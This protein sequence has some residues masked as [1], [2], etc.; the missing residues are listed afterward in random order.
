MLRKIRRRI[1]RLFRRR[2]ISVLSA[3]VIIVLILKRFKPSDL[4]F[5]VFTRGLDAKSLEATKNLAPSLLAANVGVGR[6]WEGPT[7]NG[8]HDRY[9]NHKK[10]TSFNVN[11]VSRLPKNGDITKAFFRMRDSIEDK[12]VNV[13]IWR[14]LCC[15][16][17]NS[18]RQYPLFPT[19]PKQ[20]LLRHT[21]NSGPLGTWYGQRIMGF[22]HAPLT[23]NYTFQLDAHVFAELWLS[24]KQN[25]KD[26]ELI[27]KIATQNDKNSLARP[28]GRISRKVYLEE[29]GKYFFDVLHVMNGGMMSRDHV[30][31]TWKVPGSDNFTEV[32]QTFLSPLL[33]NT[34]A[35]LIHQLS[36][37]QD[38]LLREPRSTVDT[39][40][41][42]ADAG[43]DD[44]DYIGIEI[45]KRQSRLSDEFSFY[46]GEDF[47]IENR[48]DKT[49]FEQLWD[50][51]DELL[52]VLPSCSYEPTYTKK[53]KFKQFEGIWQTHF[54][55]VS[56]DDGT[57]EFI[58]I[59]NKQKKDCD[60]ND[61]IKQAELLPLVQMLKKKVDGKYPGYESVVCCSIIPPPPLSSLDFS[62]SSDVLG[63]TPRCSLV[64]RN[65]SVF[66]MV[67]WE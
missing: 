4:R 13:H 19:L 14:G 35:Y 54:S 66:K 24:E 48:Y 60:G 62:I 37:K 59:G 6:D 42:D 31:V 29:G 32:S 15:P 50:V 56:P 55:S 3:I 65:V 28:V 63:A 5:E 25:V 23:G 47:D 16:K 21:I 38:H 11:K 8:S 41:N 9:H 7:S 22:I 51:S 33:N 67:D 46:F 2:W 45:P 10:Q 49:I 44:E 26:V 43:E 20:C 17:V 39:K 57:K 64:P 52:S 36:K 18:L 34:P 40:V 1:G 30:N 58:C 53:R 12:G 61:F 27:A